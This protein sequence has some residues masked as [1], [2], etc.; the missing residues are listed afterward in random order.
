ML[1]E[2]RVRVYAERLAEKGDIDT[3]EKLCRTIM[4][5]CTA[6]NQIS[7]ALN[8][9]SIL[10]DQQGYEVL[11]LLLDGM[12]NTDKA[13]RGAVL[14]YATQITD[15]GATRQWMDLYPKLIP[16]AQAELIHFFGQRGDMIVVP[17]VKEGLLSDDQC[18]RQASIIA[19]G[20]LTAKAAIETILNFMPKASKEDV[21]VAKNVLSTLIGE[22]EVNLLARHFG[23]QNVEGKVALL[24]LFAA[25]N[26]TLYYKLVRENLKNLLPGNWWKLLNVEIL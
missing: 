16:E 10:V 23:D 4:K 9:L 3:S 6:P 15:I 20:D 12:K 25:R 11:D 18:V 5:K 13:Y 22:N 14:R 8:A 21:A 24:E 26:A 17:L 1:N 19:L 7:Y 2:L